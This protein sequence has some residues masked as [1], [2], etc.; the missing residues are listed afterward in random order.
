MDGLTEPAK[1][2]VNQG[3]AHPNNDQPENTTDQTYGQRANSFVIR[4]GACP[5]VRDTNTTQYG[6]DHSGCNAL[7]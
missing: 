2:D 1:H 3:G 7:P 6:G 5:D 4:C